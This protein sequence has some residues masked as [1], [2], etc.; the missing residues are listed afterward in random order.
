ME[1]ISLEIDKELL[2]EIRTLSAADKEIQEIQRK[3]ASRTTLKGKIALGLCGE[4]SRLLIYDGLIWILD[5]NN[6]QLRI[7][8]DHHD[9]QAVGHPSQARTLELISQNFYRLQQ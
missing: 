3:K 4:K 7:L 6:L 8:R 2:K 5:N 1:T 9:T